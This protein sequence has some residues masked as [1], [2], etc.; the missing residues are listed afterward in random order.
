MSRTLA[1][2]RNALM[3]LAAMIAALAALAAVGSDA[4]LASGESTAF[5]ALP[6]GRG[7]ELVSPTDNAK[8]NVYAGWPLLLSNEG[9]YTELPED[10]AA[11]GNAFAY[12]AEPSEEGGAGREGATYGNQ[13]IAR[14]NAEGRWEASNMTPP[15]DEFFTVPYYQ[16]FNPELTEGLL[17]Y[18]G[19]VPL[20][21]GAPAERFRVPYA[22]NFLTGAYSS[23][24]PVQPPNTARFEFGAYGIGHA[25]Y[26][27]EPVFAGATADFSHI[28]YIAD[29]ALAPGAEY[30][31]EENNL[32][33]FSGGSLHLVNILPNGETER[34]AVF[35]GPVLPRDYSEEN[36]PDFENVLSTD[37][38]RIFWSGRGANRNIYMR[39]DG[40]RTVQIDA[41]AGG[42]GQYWNA[43]PS[44]SKVLFTKAGDLY[45]YDV[46]TEQTTDL[47]PG[48]EVQGLVGT[49][50]DL[51]YVYFVANAV[52]ASGASPGNCVAAAGGAGEQCNLYVLRQGQP[53]RFIAT[54]SGKD[55]WTEPTSFGAKHGDWQGGLGDREAEVTPSGESALFSS[56]LPLTGYDNE[57]PG[58]RAEELF[59]YE[60]GSAKLRCI[61]CKP[62]GAPAESVITTEGRHPPYSAYLPTSHQPTYAL[63]WMSSDGSRVFFE[64]L[65]SLVPAD[66]NGLADVY[67]WERGDAGSCQE[68]EGCLYLLSGAAAKSPSG[69]SGGAGA[70]FGEG[71]YLLDASASGDDVFFTSRAKLVPEDD[72][73]NIMVYDA[74]VGA[75]RPP[76]QPQCTGTGCQGL[77]SAPPV[78]ATPASVTYN[79]VGNFPAATSQAK[80]KATRGKRHTAGRHRARRHRGHRHRARGHRSRRD[81]Q[82]G[83]HAA[84]SHAHTSSKRDGRGK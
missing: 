45:E 72:T 37:G 51:S 13:Y 3:G 16:A 1:G 40:S 48:G 12:I 42:G 43:T 82:G 30:N 67:E 5:P 21:P 61:S 6:D 71:A 65:E 78:F 76:A 58:G 33:D 20:V 19:K 11:S 27:T 47:V 9:G 77:P 84:R 63:H 68:A 60:Y 32:Y 34:N 18:N 44:G 70:A 59:L 17:T 80:G 73:E 46:E 23:L 64:S 53:V 50:E 38:S 55:N 15:A 74:H 56:I 49:S 2:F 57:T 22:R 39:E 41:G 62:S 26:S 7:Y 14:R 36:A 28:L 31:E 83:G 75:T 29:D 25:V 69:L 35:G 66:N 24:L 4:A 81:R 10:A 79:G 8:G 54:L 52:L